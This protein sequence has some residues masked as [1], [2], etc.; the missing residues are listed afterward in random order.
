MSTDQLCVIFG[1]VRESLTQW[2]KGVK[3][4]IPANKKWREKNAT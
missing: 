4:I 3:K 2:K 1:N